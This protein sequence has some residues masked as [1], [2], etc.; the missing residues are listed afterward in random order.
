MPL[1]ESVSDAVR[2][3]VL[4]DGMEPEEKRELLESLA[5][6]RQAL[7]DAV[8][9]FPEEAARDASPGRWS[10]LECVEHVAVAE[11]Y[12]L[13]RL[14]E[15]KAAGDVAIPRQREALIRERA[16]NR[17]RTVPAPESALPAGRYAT[18]AAALADFLETRQRTIRFVSEC[19]EDLRAKIT[20]HPILGAATCQETLL[21]MAA[22]PLRHAKQIAE[23]RQKARSE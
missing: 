7:L 5:V 15:G 22:H 10:V 2:S 21:M 12:L 16:A 4:Y 13:A 9:E 18:L 19:Q 23:I 6:G 20:T 17:S 8:G 1:S 11:K 14:M 3:L